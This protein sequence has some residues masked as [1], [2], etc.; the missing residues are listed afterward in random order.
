MKLRIVF[1]DVLPCTRRR[2]NLKLNTLQ[3]LVEH[4]ML[5]KFFGRL[6]RGTDNIKHVIKTNFRGVQCENVK[7]PTIE[8][9]AGFFLLQ[10]KT[11]KSRYV[12]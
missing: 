2:E 1:W 4:F 10:R 3:F 12:E 6:R 8:F 5:R 9:K 7:W 11:T